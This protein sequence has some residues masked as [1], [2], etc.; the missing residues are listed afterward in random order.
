MCRVQRG[1]D[2]IKTSSPQIPNQC[3]CYFWAASSVWIPAN[4]LIVPRT[5]TQVFSFISVAFK[6]PCMSSSWP[7]F[8]PCNPRET[9]NWWWI[10]LPCLE[11]KENTLF[12]N[13][14]SCFLQTAKWA[15]WGPL[16]Q[17]WP[18]Q[19]L[20]LH[21]H[22]HELQYPPHLSENFQIYDPTRSAKWLVSALSAATEAI[23]IMRRQVNERA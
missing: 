6:T 4:V 10:V 19:F 12:Q 16:P 3:H 13:K 21:H 22:I 11:D 5:T 18:H 14:T 17:Q 9:E 15:G 8:G 2:R 23:P 20:F 1:D 7:S